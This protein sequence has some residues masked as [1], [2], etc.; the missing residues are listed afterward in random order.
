MVRKSNTGKP[1]CCR[2][3]A[4]KGGKSVH[5][6]TKAAMAGCVAHASTR[7]I[8]TCCA[9]RAR[10]I[11]RSGS[12]NIRRHSV[13]CSSP[14]LCS[15]AVRR[16]TRG[17]QMFRAQRAGIGGEDTHLAFRPQRALHHG[18]L[19]QAGGAYRQ[20]DCVGQFLLKM[21]LNPQLVVMANMQSD[22]MSLA[23]AIMRARTCRSGF[24]SAVC[25]LAPNTGLR[26]EVGIDQVS[27]ATSYCALRVLLSNRTADRFGSEWA[28]PLVTTMI[29]AGNQRVNLHASPRL[30]RHCHDNQ[31]AQ[32]CV[33]NS[34][35]G[36]YAAP[37]CRQTRLPAP[38]LAPATGMPVEFIY[39]C[40]RK[41]PP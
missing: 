36:R 35:S 2:I 18:H 16:D 6:S 8:R 11:S 28:W 5:S 25:R 19:Q 40:N 1:V 17:T 4:E 33:G 3:D 9:I 13:H 34:H 27:S 26:L 12:A 30:S 31:K 41:H 38:T 15:P 10:S 14:T 7:M 22:A 29:D 37:R 32:R 23:S 20:P 21:A 24:S 39:L